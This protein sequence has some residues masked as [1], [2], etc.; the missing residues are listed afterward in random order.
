MER[1]VW[2]KAII[3]DSLDIAATPQAKEQ[4]TEQA[5]NES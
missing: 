4:P 5:E 2:A 1:L 3:T